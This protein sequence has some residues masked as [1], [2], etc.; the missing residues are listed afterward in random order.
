[1]AQ[2]MNFFAQMQKQNSSNTASAA[3]PSTN[4]GEQSRDLS[5]LAPAS[6][7]QLTTFH[8]DAFTD[9]PALPSESANGLASAPIPSLNLAMIK[10]HQ[11]N[12]SSHGQPKRDTIG[13]SSDTNANNCD[14]LPSSSSLLLLGL[15]RSNPV[16][17]AIVDGES[18]EECQPPTRLPTSR[19]ATATDSRASTTEPDNFDTPNPQSSHKLSNARRQGSS[20]ARRAS[21]SINFDATAKIAAPRSS[22]KTAATTFKSPSAPSNMTS[23]RRGH[24]KNAASTDEPQVAHELVERTPPPQTRQQ[25]RRK[26]S[27]TSHTA[28]AHVRP[29]SSYEM[30]DEIQLDDGQNREEPVRKRVKGEPVDDEVGIGF[31]SCLVQSP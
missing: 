19:S 15:N 5:L 2:R 20:T 10:Q 17:D 1:M 29:R 9:P 12:S 3:N 16:S 7:F 8:V 30:D 14:P 28:S 18:R 24:P 27:I 11:K 21:G 6:Y 22:S 23:S 13:D 25:P 31:A 4:T 26:M